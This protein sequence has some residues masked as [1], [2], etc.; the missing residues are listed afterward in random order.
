[1]AYAF[2]L[3]AAA[4]FG[5]SI[6]LSKS[7]LGEVPPVPLAGMLYLASGIGTG[8]LAALRRGGEAP[9]RRADAGRLGIVIVAGGIAAPLLLLFGLSRTP[10]HVSA[11]LLTTETLFTV[12]FAVLFFGDHLVRREWLGAAV[13][14]AGA[15]AVAWPGAAGG[16][17]EWIGP[18]LVLGA[19]LAWGVDNNV[20]QQ[21][22]GRDPLQ[23]AAIKGIVAGS[24]NLAIAGD[25]TPTWRTVLY[26][27]AVGFFCYG[28]SL[29]L[30][31]HAL[32]RLGA[33]RTSSIWATAP[34]FGVFLSWLFLREIPATLAL[35]G[36]AAMI[37]GT[38]LF[39]RADHRHRHVHEA[40]D[41]EHRHVHDEHHRHEH[42]GDEGPEPHSHP[43]R[44]ERLEHDHP[45]VADFHHHHPH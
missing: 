13:L 45:H 17:L 19:C 15:L 2:V 27:G 35:A 18:V 23:I 44:H 5:A 7:L 41:H 29:A 43:H 22:S 14:L 8:M 32:R 26:A 25:W 10:A 21:L 3:I 12:A 1:M 11:L 34:V 16:R 20:T 33:A 36:G 40:I 28:L 6:P 24:V 4:L 31:V 38:W 39:I 42:R 9:I 30:F 37:A